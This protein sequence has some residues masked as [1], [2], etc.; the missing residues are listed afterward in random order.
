M[1]KIHLTKGLIQ[2]ATPFSNKIMGEEKDTTY[3]SFK[4]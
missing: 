4:L 1:L 2:G 3:N